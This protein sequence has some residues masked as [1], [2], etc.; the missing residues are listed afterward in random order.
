MMKNRWI[1]V[2]I[3]LGSNLGNREKSIRDSWKR[4]AEVSG[5]RTV[6]LSRLIETD[7]VGGPSDQPSFLNGAGILETERNPF[8]LLNC[9]N[10]VE[11]AGGR[12]R[13]QFWG[14]RTIDLDILLYGSDIIQTKRL[15]IPHPRMAWRPFVL[16]PASEIAPEMFHP[17]WKMSVKEMRDLAAMN[18]RLAAFSRIPY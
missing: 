3:A 16:E 5:I 13:H 9:L 4:L 14:A 1:S 7:P 12:E 10:R 2:L 17:V 6:R 18:F 15:T 11:K 8:E